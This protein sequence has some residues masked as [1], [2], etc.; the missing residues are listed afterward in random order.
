MA[1]NSDIRPDAQLPLELEEHTLV[2]APQNLPPSHDSHDAEDTQQILQE[3]RQS[4]TERAVTER[5]TRKLDLDKWHLRHHRRHRPGL[6]RVGL[7]RPGQPS[8]TVST[9]VLDW[10]MEYTGWLFMVLASLFVVFVL[11]LAL[12]KFGNIPLGKDGEKPE[13]RTV[14][15][16]A[17]MFAAGMGI[18]LMFYGVA[19]PLY[20]YISPPPGNGGRTDPRS[21]PDGHGHLH[22]PLDPAPL[23]HVRSGRHRHGLRHLPPGPQTTHLGRVHLALWHQDGRRTG[24]Q[25][26]QHPGNL[27]HACSVPP[28]RWAWGPSRSAAA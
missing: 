5:R 9:D 15:W 12:G 22:L 28:R 14:S 10:V 13:F 26:H 27:R 4:K 24:R 25:V 16:I 3:L 8:A 21:H 7:P 20:H 19:E 11:W 2:P 6:R 23:G 18:G 1:L 17:M